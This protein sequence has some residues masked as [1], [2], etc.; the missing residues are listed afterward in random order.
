MKLIVGLGNPG[1]QYARHRHNAGFM[2]LDRLHARGMG[3]EWREKYVG[4][5]ARAIIAG[6][7]VTLLKP[8]TFMNLSGR[9][10]VRALQ[11]MGAAIK[12]VLVL[13][14]ELELPFGEIR[15]KVGGGHGG[16]NGL[17]DITATAG[18]DFARVR[19][20]IGRPAQGAVDAYVLAGFSKDEAPLL[21][22]MLDRAADLAE[23]MVGEGPD[24]VIAKANAP[25]KPAG[26]N[27]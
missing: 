10:V 6:R 27:R 20:G 17:R 5:A 7:E 23:M 18:A 19:V 16:H 13:H 22:A 2:V 12:D 25:K 8:Q 15:P 26:R 9:S 4:L 24:T 1:A 14:D 21:D 3:S 11:Q